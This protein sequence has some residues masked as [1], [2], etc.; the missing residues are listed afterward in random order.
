MAEVVTE[1][2]VDARGVSMGLAESAQAS[3]VAQAALDRYL[4]RLT[5]A[6]EVSDQQGA[7]LMRQSTSIQRA[8]RDWENLKKSLDDNYRS[9]SNLEAD[10]IKLDRA[11][12]RLG[13]SQAEAAQWLDK[14]VMKHDAAAR[15]AREQTLEYQ[16]LAQAGR[17]ALALDM[18]SRDGQAMWNSY[19]GV[20]EPSAVAR[21]SAAIFQAELDRM[22][23]IAGMK[24]RQ[25]GQTFGANLDAS[26]IAGTGKSARDA[27]SVFSIELDRMDEIARLRATEAGA[28]F[29]SDLNTRLGVGG[30]VSSARGSA[31]VFIEMDREAEA[32][33]KRLALVRA[34]IDPLTMA[35][36]RQ[37]VEL[38]EL[39][40]MYQ[41]GDLSAQ[42]FA[43]GQ[44]VAQ[45]RV[46]QVRAHLMHVG[47]SREAGGNIMAGLNSAQ[48]F[49]DILITSMMGQGIGTIALQQG[50]QLGTAAMMTGAGGP[51]G[52]AT[53]LRSSLAALTHPLML[54]A[55]GFTAITAAAIQFFSKSGKGP[56]HSTICSKNRTRSSTAL[57]PA[58]RK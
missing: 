25:I 35:I 11:V 54:G 15:A 13:V 5:A 52:L 2:T 36:E 12:T 1:L 19:A 53:A 51:I 26:L 21:D 32:Y 7:S 14:V 39:A 50:T 31:S 42:Q 57:A 23:E 41:R 55:V 28:A 48:Q 44:V 3:Q 16:R 29:T 40:V 9:A 18:S 30:P 46:E 38:A 20:R 10:F 17:E 22:D 58:T 8:A 24:A 43:Q 37:Q 49:Q 6:R 56:R 27:A 4:D 34:D 33:Q 45:Q 47:R